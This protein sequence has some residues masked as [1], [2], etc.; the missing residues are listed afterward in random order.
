MSISVTTPIITQNNEFSPVTLTSTST[1]V[2]PKKRGRAKKN[3]GNSTT[4]TTNT[5]TITITPKF[6]KNDDILPKEGATHENLEG[7]HTSYKNEV[8]LPETN[9][10]N[11]KMKMNIR[12]HL[13]DGSSTVHTNGIDVDNDTNDAP[14][15]NIC[16]NNLSQSAD[17]SEEHC[18]EDDKNDDVDGLYKLT[19]FNHDILI[20]F[21][22]INMHASSRENILAL[23]QLTLVNCIEGRCISEGFIKPRTV[24]I[25][26]FKCGKIVSRNVQFNLVIECLVCNPIENFTINCIANTITQAG[27][28]A[29]SSDK[30]LPVVIYI[31]RDY[32]ILTQNT[33]YNSVKEGD[34]I[35]IKVIGKRFEMND[36]FI[37]IIG[38][39]ISPKKECAPLKNYKKS[40]TFPSNTT[41]NSNSIGEIITSSSVSSTTSSATT[42]TVHETKKQSSTGTKAPKAPKEPKAPKAPKEPKA[43]KAPKEPKTKLKSNV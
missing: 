4:T 32:S 1:V 9:S 2:E 15:E 33:Y 35:T 40:Y 23:L 21:Q 13:N 22:I 20:P 24:R 36:K 30:H 5:T 31:S 29:I 27:I 37:Q 19:R 10:T 34:N 17:N 43:P 42:E 28:R 12:I 16:S 8:V 18:I 3:A 11:N 14:E 7:E 6:I 26:D 38:E 41:V 25:V 39:L